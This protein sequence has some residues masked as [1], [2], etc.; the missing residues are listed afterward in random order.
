[1][2]TG[3]PMGDA[4]WGSLGGVVLLG[5]NMSLRASSEVSRLLAV[6]S[7]YPLCFVPVVRDT[8]SQLTAPATMPDA[9]LPVSLPSWILTL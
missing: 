8:S 7:I 4:I 1:M 3:S 5:G 9:C 6:F 2:S